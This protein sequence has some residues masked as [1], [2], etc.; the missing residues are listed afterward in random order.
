MNF[1]H[2]PQENQ[3]M[4]FSTVYTRI[5]RNGT[6][7]LRGAP[8]IP[9]LTSASLPVTVMLISQM[10]TFPSKSY[11]TYL[12]AMSLKVVRGVRNPCG[13]T[14]KRAIDPLLSIAIGSVRLTGSMPLG[15]LRT[16]IG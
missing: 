15:P 1:S 2:D 8:I 10:A 9:K 5:S 13:L 11:A 3:D 16:M 6:S 14:S 7:D 12:T 4:K